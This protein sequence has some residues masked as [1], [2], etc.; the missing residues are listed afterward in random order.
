MSSAVSIGS[1]PPCPSYARTKRGHEL[2]ELLVGALKEPVQPLDGLMGYFVNI[3]FRQEEPARG[4]VLQ[5]LADLGAGRHDVVMTRLCLGD[6]Q[7]I[8]AE[9]R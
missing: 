9:V 8:T 5:N 1:E 2:I 7:G 6:G 3:V 4:L